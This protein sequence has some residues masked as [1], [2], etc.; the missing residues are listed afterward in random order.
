MRIDFALKPL[1]EVMPWGTPPDQVLHWYGLTYGYYRI[2]LGNVKLFDYTPEVMTHW[3]VAYPGADSDSRVDYQVARLWEDVIEALAPALRPLPDRLVAIMAD[4]NGWQEQCMGWWGAQ[5]DTEEAWDV[6]DLATAWVGQR[7]LDSGYLNPDSDVWMWS[8]DESVF[9]Q[10][11]NR[12]KL[13]EGIPAWTAQHGRCEITVSDFI[14]ALAVFNAELFRQMQVRVDA[15]EAGWC[16]PGATI[17]VPHLKREQRERP[18]LFA[19]AFRLPP[20]IDWLATEAA[21]ERIQRE[22]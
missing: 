13:V 8:H 21:C 10:W 19:Q 5:P 7:Y 3:A 1:E 6:F 12:D 17:D 4:P 16:P 11:D 15:V 18:W 9:I 14:E 20:V 22:T 2:D